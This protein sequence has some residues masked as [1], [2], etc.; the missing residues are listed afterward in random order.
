MAEIHKECTGEKLIYIFTTL[1]PANQEGLEIIVQ[2]CSSTNKYQY[3]PMSSFTVRFAEKGI[4]RKKNQ[5]IIAFH[6]G[7]FGVLAEC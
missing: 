5:A 2:Q 6:S 1:L 4:V 3:K 7:R